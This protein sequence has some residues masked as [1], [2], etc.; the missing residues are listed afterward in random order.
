MDIKHLS[1]SRHRSHMDL[2]MQLTSSS[3]SCLLPCHSQVKS[4]YNFSS[5]SHN[6]A[7]D[8]ST[9]KPKKL[10]PIFG[11]VLQLEP[12][13]YT[14]GY[15]MVWLAGLYPQTPPGYVQN[16]AQKKRQAK[17]Q[18]PVHVCIWCK[19]WM[20]PLEFLRKKSNCGKRRS[21]HTGVLKC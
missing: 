21:E 7:T 3:S 10:N 19:G 18:G 4:W 6:L 8:S 20:S 5:H 11:C 2:A 12:C 16:S 14:D 13:S 15:T 9:F 17:S 1:F